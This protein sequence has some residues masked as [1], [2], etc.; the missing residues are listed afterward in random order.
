[1]EIIHRKR[2][3]TPFQH[4]AYRVS[5]SI[6]MDRMNE[7]LQH[8]EQ[9]LAAAWPA[10]AWRNRVVLLAVSGGADSVA[11]L[12]GM[13]RLAQQKPGSGRLIVAH[14]NH[15][16]RGEASDADEQFVRQLAASLGLACEVGSRDTHLPMET[17]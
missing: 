9:Q 2:F 12:R 15:N 16:L 6:I 13:H 17:G 5:R 10:D 4:A 3:L 1:M 8:F 14:F 11:L 7:P